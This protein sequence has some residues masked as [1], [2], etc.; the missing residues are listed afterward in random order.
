MDPQTVTSVEQ[1]VERLRGLRHR[2]KKVQEIDLQEMYQAFQGVGN[3]KPVDQQSFQFD[4]LLSQ[5][6]SSPSKSKLQQLY[7]SMLKYVEG[8]L[9]NAS[10]QDLDFKVAEMIEELQKKLKERDKKKAR[11]ESFL[12]AQEPLSLRQYRVLQII[13]ERQPEKVPIKAKAICEQYNLQY[14]DD[15]LTENVLTSSVIPPLKKSCHVKHFHN[16]GYFT[17]E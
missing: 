12:D 7:E 10:F 9:D 4:E 15:L 14:P 6:E 17:S 5:L 13:H 3:S 16:K 1:I 8:E 11:W 2:W